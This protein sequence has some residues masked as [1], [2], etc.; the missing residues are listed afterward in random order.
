MPAD[1]FRVGPHGR[2]VHELRARSKSPQRHCADFV[3]RIGRT[4][5]HDSIARANVMQQEIAEGME[6]LASD[7][8]RDQVGTPVNG[9]ARRRG[10]HGLN[11]TGRAADLFEDGL[12][13]NYLRGDGAARRDF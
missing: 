6:L 1:R 12:P 13:L 10:R 8:R 9:S 5:L 3:L 11:V 7:G 2:V 4:V